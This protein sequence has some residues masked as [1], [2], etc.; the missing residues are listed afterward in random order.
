MLPSVPWNQLQDPP[1]FPFWKVGLSPHPCSQPLCLSWPLPGVSSTS[2]SLAYCPTLTLSLCWFTMFV[3]WE[4]HSE[5]L[6]PCL[7]PILQNRFIITPP[8]PLLVLDH[9]LLFMFF[10]FVRRAVQSSQGLH[11][12]M[13]PVGGGLAHGVCCSPVLSADSHKQLWRNGS[14]FLRAV[15]HREAFHGLGVQDVTEFDSDW[16]FVFC[17][18]EERKLNK[19]KW[20]GG[21]FPR[22]RHTLLAVP[23]GIFVA[24][25]CN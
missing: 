5:S 22:T 19:K 10:S 14:T 17:L 21:F 16:C 12:I 13:F 9:S 23:C 4:F 3:H 8:P 7:I 6:V 25:R 20:P 2:G 1:P 24:V 15:H 18:L 11:W